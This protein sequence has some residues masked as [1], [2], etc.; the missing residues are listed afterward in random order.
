MKPLGPRAFRQC[1]DESYQGWL[2]T[3]LGDVAETDFS[4]A[5]ATTLNRLRAD[6]SR[7][8]GFRAVTMA[9]AVQKMKEGSN[10]AALAPSQNQ[11][12]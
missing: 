8:A 10:A 5:A 4:T 2:A 11:V 9:G 1:E 12:F 3:Q 6:C 7:L